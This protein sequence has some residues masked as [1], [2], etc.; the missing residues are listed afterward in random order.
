MAPTL[1]KRVE[2]LS[3][4]TL[5]RLHSLPRSVMPVLILL[6]MFVGLVKDNVIGGIA[7]LIVAAFVGWLLYLSWPLLEGRA[8]IIRALAVLLVVAA[9]FSKFVGK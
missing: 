3:A 6:F 1:R 7:L 5:I 8:R 2:V 9:S 4:P